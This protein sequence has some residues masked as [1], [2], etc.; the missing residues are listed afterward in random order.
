MIDMKK[1]LQYALLMALV[2]MIAAAPVQAS[3]PET[4]IIGSTSDPAGLLLA[5]T[6]LI[7]IGVAM[8][9]KKTKV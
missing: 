5:G 6:A 9:R 4:A 8:K 2:W 1:I 7:A 3:G